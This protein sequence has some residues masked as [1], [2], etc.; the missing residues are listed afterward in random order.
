MYLRSSATPGVAFIEYYVDGWKLPDMNTGETYGVPLDYSLWYEFNYWGERNLEVRAYDAAWNLV[1]TW[2]QT[3]QVPS[4]ALEVSW[5]RL[6]YKSYRFDGD[7]PAGTAKVVIEIDGWA[8]PDK[9]SG[10]QWAVGP[11]FILNYDFNYGGYREL[12]AKALD[13]A[14]NVLDTYTTNI[15]VY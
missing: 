7:A 11:D 8:L 1:D 6:G 15:Q 2:T 12:H 4:P 5:Q 13:S 10:D 3:I 9:T 14:G